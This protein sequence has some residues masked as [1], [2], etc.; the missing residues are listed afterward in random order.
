MPMLRKCVVALGLLALV[1]LP[2]VAEEVP[3]KTISD[4]G[5]TVSYPP[6]MEATAKR[7]LQ[8]ALASIRPSVEIQ[9]QIAALTSNADS[10]AQ[11]IV[12]LLGSEEVKEDTKNR[13]L[14]YKDKSAALAAC[15]S[16]IRLVPKGDA[17]A[18]GGVDAGI[19]QVRYEP[20]R[21]QFMTS[22]QTGPD[23][24]GK[25]ARSYYPVIV[26][27]DGS[28]PSE[29]KVADTAQDFLGA[30]KA[31]IVASVH[32]IVGYIITDKLRIYHP[33][34]RWFNDGVAGWVTR[35]AVIKADP[36]LK[37]L[38][39][40]M[41]NVS[42]ASKRL[43]DKIN[44]I[45]WPQVAFQ[46]RQSSD[47]DATMEAA[48]TQYSIEIISQLVGGNRGDMLAKIVSEAKYSDNPDTNAILAAIKKAAGTDLKKTLMTYVPADV[49]HGMETGG[50]KKLASQAEK[51]VQEKSWKA[52]ADKLRA[53]LQMTPDDLNM[54]LNLAWI[55]REIP[56]RTD[57]EMQVFIASRLVRQ[58][59]YSFHMYAPSI[60]GNYILGRFALLV[61]NLD[62]A[63][64]FL[65]PVVQLKPDHEDAK[66]ALEEI[67][68][69]EAA[70]T[71]GSG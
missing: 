61:R 59:D 10:L 47:F 71:G 63:K 6:N 18:M 62:M 12:N 57:S 34:A 27:A 19:L 7:V 50:A 16:N 58:K 70:L 43:R 15:F 54:R 9:K 23:A 8:I 24:A 69:L 35:K 36:K 65:E 52:A 39:D 56:D 37:P 46:N 41:F 42:P 22:I 31:M 45:A 28:I 3:L 51:L 5:I 44:L 55:E 48:Q 64:Q 33:F 20:D 32:E 68:R 21:D 60:E 29:K 40:E 53:A 30:N 14:A 49:R 17:V 4:A 66:R 1:I 11:D 2:A 67:R 26:N 38:A 25:L 13:L